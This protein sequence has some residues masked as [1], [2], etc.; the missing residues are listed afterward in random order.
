MAAN[1]KIMKNKHFLL[2]LL[3][4]LINIAAIAGSSSLM[5]SADLSESSSSPCYQTMG[6]C[7]AWSMNYKCTEKSTSERCRLYAC[8]SCAA[9]N[10]ELPTP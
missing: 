1:L 7:S 8:E 3:V 6:Y 10:P 4:A 9:I 5:L 2:L